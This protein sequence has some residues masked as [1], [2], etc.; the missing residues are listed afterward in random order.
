MYENYWQ[1]DRKPFDQ[2]ADADFYYPAESH[3]AALF[4]LR[5]AIEGRHGTALLAGPGGSGKTLLLEMLA[6][7]TAEMI[8]PVVRLVFP[9]M[10]AANLLSYLAD[11]MDAPAANQP[12][13]TIDESV[14]R[15]QYVLTENAQRGKHA[16][17][18]IDE[19]HLLEDR[20]A[21]EALRL[22]LNFEHGGQP[23][24]TLVLSGDT[25]LLTLVERLPQWDERIAA[26]CLLSR[27]TQEETF[28]YVTH[29]LKSAGAAKAIFETEALETLHELSQGLPRRINRL[30]DLALLVG[31]ADELPQITS[32]QIE[33]AVQELSCSP[34]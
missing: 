12:R 19:A 16:V 21:L 34:R 26:R 7:Q 22:L 17:V 14:R 8:S 32:S 5:Y 29:R 20:S 28:S 27:F 4:K 15:I 13:H 3:Q 25:S 33:A 30:A 9:Q 10:P 24:L 23:L 1:L 31:F 2:S 18:A 11:E 6:R